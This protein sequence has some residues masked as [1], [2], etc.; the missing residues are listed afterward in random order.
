MVIFNS[1]VSLPEGNRYGCVWD[2]GMAMLVGKLLLM[3]QWMEW[4]TMNGK[5]GIEAG[6]IN[7][8]DGMFDMINLWWC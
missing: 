3:N 4:L 6:G 8:E 5:Y 2:W 1:Y 7:S